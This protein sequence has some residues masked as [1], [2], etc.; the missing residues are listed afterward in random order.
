MR[1]SIADWDGGETNI[2]TTGGSFSF[3]IAKWVSVLRINLRDV[4]E[5]YPFF[6][7]FFYFILFICGFQSDLFGVAKVRCTGF[8]LTNENSGCGQFWLTPTSSVAALSIPFD[9]VLR[10]K[11]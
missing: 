2:E 6:Y 1:Q 11:I 9:L 8:Q 5:I 7:L 10:G 3:L 4:T